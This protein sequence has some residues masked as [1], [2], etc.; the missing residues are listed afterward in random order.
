MKKKQLHLIIGI[1]AIIILVAVIMFNIFSTSENISTDIEDPFFLTIESSNVDYFEGAQGY[2]AKPNDNEKHPGLILIH[3]WWGLNDQIMKTADRFAEEGYVALA[4]DL[5]SGK[6][7]TKSSKAG[8]L[9]SSVRNDMPAAFE[10]LQAAVDYLNSHPNVEENKLASVGW[11][12]GG[13]WSYEMAKNDLGIDGSVIY[14]GQFNP[15]DDLS[16]MRANI[17]GHFGED[18]ATILVDDVIAFEAKLQ[19]LE[20]EHQI[21]I[22]PNSGHAFGNEESSSYNMESAD[23]AWSRTLEFLDREIR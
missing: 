3:E 6:V 17:L 23:L 7:T 2:L 15:E 13:G 22:Y 20:G 11:C 12:F 14:Y 5:Y 1:I 18:D 19:T 10:N 9:A 21:F 16:I 4:V 8:E